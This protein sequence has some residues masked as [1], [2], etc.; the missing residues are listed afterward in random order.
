MVGNVKFDLQPAAGIIDQGRSLRAAFGAGRPVW[1]A[2]STHAGEEEQL[3]D[4]HARLLTE[5]P[6]A[7]LLLV[8]R[9]KDRFAAVAELLARRGVRFA[10]PQRAASRPTLS[11][12]CC[13][14]IRWENSRCCTPRL[15]W[16]LSAAAWWPWAGTICSSPRLSGCRY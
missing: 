13:W 7:L 1:I 2:G 4:A 6:D 12:R 9:H 14:S 3:L 5:Q 8:P 15:M 16:P 11:A 10:P